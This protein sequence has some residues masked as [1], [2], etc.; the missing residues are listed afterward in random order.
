MQ[1]DQPDYDQPVAYDKDGNPLYAHPPKRQDAEMTHQVDP[2]EPE[3]SPE[4][5]RRHEESVS[6]YPS[7][8]LSKEEYI[9]SEVRRHPIGLVL[10]ITIG[11]VLVLAVLG[12]LSMYSTFV[13]SGN[14][15]LSSVLMRV[16]CCY[17]ISWE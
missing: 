2:V 1:P 17:D 9:I 15:P 13:P 6:R 10:P 11:S 4:T 3:V 12:V 16:H 14:P 8:N 5:K 7:L